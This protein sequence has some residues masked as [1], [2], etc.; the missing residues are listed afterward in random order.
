MNKKTLVIILIAS[1]FT[2]AS[3]KKEYSCTCKNF[4]YGIKDKAKTLDKMSKSKAKE[5]CTAIQKTYYSYPTVTCDI[6]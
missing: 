1:A 2:V 6:Q 3:C 5:T 4:P